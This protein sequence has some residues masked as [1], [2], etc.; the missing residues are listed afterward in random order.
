METVLLRN[1][2]IVGW[3]FASG[4]VKAIWFFGADAIEI[5]DE[6]REVIERVPIERAVEED[7]RAA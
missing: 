2:Q 4:N 6:N 7:Q 3:T 5:L 1:R